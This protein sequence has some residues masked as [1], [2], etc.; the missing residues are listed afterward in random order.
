MDKNF[1]FFILFR[2]YYYLTQPIIFQCNETN[3]AKDVNKEE[4]KVK[5]NKADRLKNDSELQQYSYF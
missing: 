1:E 4:R 2:M 3:T 5:D